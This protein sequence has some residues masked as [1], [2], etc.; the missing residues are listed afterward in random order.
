[1]MHHALPVNMTNVQCIPGEGIQGTTAIGNHLVRAGNP[2]WLGIDRLTI[3]QNPYENGHTL[4]C[5]T[6]DGVRKADLFLKSKIRPTAKATI[7]N[8]HDR[9][10]R[11][12][13]ITGDHE[14]AAAGVA[15]DLSIPNPLVEARLKPAEK[16]AYVEALQADGK[17]VMFVGDGTNDAVALKASAIGVHLNRG[18]DVAKSAADIVLMNPHLLDVCVLLDISRAAYRR[19]VLNFLWS[20]VYNSVAVLAASG[21]FRVWRIEP[22]YAGLGELVSVLPVIGVAFSMRWM[23]YG[24]KYRG[25]KGE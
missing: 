19:I 20:F 16:Q 6:V 2:V 23:G 1:M 12:H 3:Q 4:L 13:M 9:G 17:T 5:L 11:V 7:K 21:A 22:K 10:I 18:S 25:L 24:K 8:L 14:G 15:E